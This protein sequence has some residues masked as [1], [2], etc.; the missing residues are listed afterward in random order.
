MCRLPRR[1]RPPSR[2]G[3]GDRNG[4]RLSAPRAKDILA[5]RPE[6]PTLAEL[7]RRFGTDDDDELLLL[8]DAQTSGGLLV[9]GEV[10]GYPVVGEVVARSGATTVSVR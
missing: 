4:D 2:L 1:S 10:P 6:Q 5:N 7:H 9:V 8:A 3:G